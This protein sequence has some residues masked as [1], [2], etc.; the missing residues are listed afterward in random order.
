MGSQAKSDL[1]PLRP[2]GT[3][4]RAL[5]A[6]LVYETVERKKKR[7]ACPVYGDNGTFWNKD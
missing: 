5:Y 2:P 4:H 1:L 6:E 7:K 3:T